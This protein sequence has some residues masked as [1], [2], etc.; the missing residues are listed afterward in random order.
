MR[1]FARPNLNRYTDPQ[2][3]DLLKRW[4]R[5]PAASQ[6]FVHYEFRNRPGQVEMWING[7][8]AGTVSAGSSLRQV[9]VS[10]PAGAAIRDEASYPTDGVEEKYCALDV[11]RI[12]KPGTMREARVS[13]ANGLRRIEGIPLIVADGPGNGDVGVV[14]EMKGSWALECDEHLS[15]TPFD[16]MPETLHFSVPQACYHKAYV[17]C[18]ADPDPRKEPVL[19]IRMTRFARSGRGD[20]MTHA[21][22]VLPRRKRPLRRTRNAWARS[23]TRRTAR[24]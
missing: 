19:T 16:G 1:I 9:R 17:L 13:L 5:L 11:S 10:L 6:T 2:Q 24:P 4:D 14:R 12:A 22:V 18:A 20:A 8:Y 15:R 7:C 3:D 21:S 23:P